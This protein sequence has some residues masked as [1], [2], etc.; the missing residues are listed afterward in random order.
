MAEI[1]VQIGVLPPAQRAL[2]HALAGRLPGWILYGGT[3]LA[4]RLGHR[5]SID[6]DFFRFD[7]F[8]PM[9]LQAGCPP[10]IGATVLQRC[11][12]TLTL[13]V[14]HGAPVQVSFFGV[15]RLGQV[16]APDTASD[17]GTPIASLLDLA[18]TKAATVQVRAEAKDYLDL[19][20][21][22]GHDVGLE[23]AC[24]AALAIYGPG[25]HPLGTLKALS[26]FGDG[27][28][29]TV[30]GEVRDR[31]AAAARQVDPLR[32]PAITNLFRARRDP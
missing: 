1:P 10:L 32:L 3:A 16:L 26:Y 4:L 30:P 11:E 29:A 2:W 27:N 15:P 13:L 21:L 31:L 8:D 14:D 22:I 24:A 12:N 9:A 6:F 23:W 20:A 17:T 18:G 19:D 28:L 7:S 25:A 5:Q